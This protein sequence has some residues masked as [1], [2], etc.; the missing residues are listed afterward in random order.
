MGNVLS[1][2]GR[3]RCLGYMHAN[4]CTHTRTHTHTHI[5]AMASGVMTD[6][7]KKGMYRREKALNAVAPLNM[8]ACIKGVVQSQHT[9]QVSQLVSVGVGVRCVCVR[10]RC[11]Y[12]WM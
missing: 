10:V 3:Q 5:T 7:D 4:T 2:S 11:V 1:E 9:A 8:Q 6:A 12:M